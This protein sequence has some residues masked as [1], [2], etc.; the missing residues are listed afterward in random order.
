M[1]NIVIPMLGDNYFSDEKDRVFPLPLRE[2]CGKTILEYIVNNYQDI[3]NKQF[4]F[5]IKEYDSRRF[6]LDE[7]LRR[8]DSECQVLVVKDKTQGMAC[9]TMLAIEYIKDSNP[10]I[11][12]ND[13]QFLET[14]IGSALESFSGFDAGA[15]TFESIHPRYA[16]A[17]VNEDNLMVCAYEKNPISKHAIAGFYYF[18]KG[19]DFIAASQSMIK[20]DVN[21]EGQYFIAP[22]FNEMILQN[23]RITIFEIPKD[24]YHTFYSLA[25]VREYERIKSNESRA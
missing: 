4:I 5:I 15:I 6:H 16:Y 17:K 2:V 7:I 9:S 10:L 24:S 20:K 8:L 22:V 23:K 11:I 21:Y 3:P 25:K 13:N 12:A 19:S 1:I 14:D 18:R